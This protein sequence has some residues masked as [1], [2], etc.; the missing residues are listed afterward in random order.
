MEINKQLIYKN[1]HFLAI[2]QLAE[3]YNTKGYLVEKEKKLGKYTADLVVSKDNEKIVFEVKTGKMTP[4]RK[5]QLIKLTDY[6]NSLGDY[7]FKIIIARSPKEKN[8]QIAEF[9]ELFFDYL[10]SDLPSELDELSTHTTIESVS[11]IE[12]HDLNVNSGNKINVIGQGIVKVKLQY[13]SDG[14]GRRG[15]GLYQYESFTFDFE[16]YLSYNSQMKLIIND[17]ASI[18][19]DTYSF[20]E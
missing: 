3:E 18:E 10:L 7:K 6:V 17:N 2:E 14:D 15:D 19:I 13:G 20:Y 5:E 9:E 1:L 12:I 8:I 16:L 11:E 4:K